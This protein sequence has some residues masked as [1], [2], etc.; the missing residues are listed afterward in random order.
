MQE[1]GKLDEAII[2]YR[3]AIKEDA[4]FCDAHYNLANGMYNAFTSLFYDFNIYMPY[5][6]CV[7]MFVNGW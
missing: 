2:K 1:Q 7:F 4:T 3:S 6:N 5:S